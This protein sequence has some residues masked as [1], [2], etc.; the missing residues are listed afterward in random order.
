MKKVNFAGLIRLGTLLRYI[1][2]YTEGLYGTWLTGKRGVQIGLLNSLEEI[3][4]IIDELSLSP[5]TSEEVFGF[6]NKIKEKY[7]DEDSLSKEDKEILGTFVH[8][9]IDRLITNPEENIAILLDYDYSIN[10]KLLTNVNK[11]FSSDI[12]DKLDKETKDDLEICTKCIMF[13]LPTPAGILALRATESVLRT[14]YEKKL[15]HH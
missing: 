1:D 5:R 3:K 12:W 13:E 6:I 11:F 9:W 7:K 10:P 4:E 14:Y 2:D 8:R 15:G